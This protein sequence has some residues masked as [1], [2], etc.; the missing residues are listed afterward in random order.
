MGRLQGRRGHQDTEQEHPAAWAQGHWRSPAVTPVAEED[1]HLDDNLPVALADKGT[2]RAVALAGKGRLPVEAL[3]GKETH[4]ATAA[5][6]MAQPPEEVEQQKEHRPSYPGPTN[7]L[8]GRPK[9]HPSVHLRSGWELE[10]LH[11]FG[12]HHHCKRHRLKREKRVCEETCEYFLNVEMQMPVSILPKR[13]IAVTSIIV[14]KGTIFT[15]MITT[16]RSS[17]PDTSRQW[18]VAHAFHQSFA[19]VI[20]LLRVVGTKGRRNRGSV[21]HPTFQFELANHFVTVRLGAALCHL[22]PTYRGLVQVVH[23]VDRQL[24]QEISLGLVVV[25]IV[26]PIIKVRL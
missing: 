5:A 25:G 26:Q 4:Q 10:H 6:D 20:H 17:S 11:S 1:I 21:I 23:K 15:R 24:D 2:H 9:R 12:V 19:Q 7:R 16:H 8:P 14:T 13:T 3:A 18:R 22:V